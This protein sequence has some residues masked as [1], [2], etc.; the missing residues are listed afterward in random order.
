MNL[1]ESSVAKISAARCCAVCGTICATRTN[2]RW[3][4]ALVAGAAAH[5]LTIKRPD[6]LKCHDACKDSLNQFID[7]RRAAAKATVNV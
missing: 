6:A 1:S 3:L 2:P 4:Q 7:R 5:G